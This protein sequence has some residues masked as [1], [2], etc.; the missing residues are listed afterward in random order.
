MNAALALRTDDTERQRTERQETKSVARSCRGPVLARSRRNDAAVYLSVIPG[1]AAARTAQELEVQQGIAALLPDLSRRARYLT[2][3]PDAALDLVQDTVERALRF[4]RS[5]QAGTNLRAWLLQVMYS[6][7][8]SQ[9][10]RSSRH[11]DAVEALTAEPWHAATLNAEPV[12]QALSPAMRAHLLQ[13]P[14]A[15]AQVVW[16]VDVLELSYQEAADD[17]GVPI[18]T[19]MSRLHRARRTLRARLHDA[20]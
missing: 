12:S 15:F 9:C 18:G 20:A 10:R 13:L 3:R 19:V 2:K 11:R 14:T 7:F 5:Y 1:G 4:A 6:V 16:L 17:L 8:A